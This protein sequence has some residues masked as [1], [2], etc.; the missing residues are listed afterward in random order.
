[1]PPFRRLTLED[2][3]LF[4][5]HLGNYPYGTYEYSFT[6]LYLWRGFCHV[7]HAIIDDALVVK[8]TE[9]KPGAFFMPP[10]G[11]TPQNLP[12]I[13]D[14]IRKMRKEIGEMPYLF[15]DAEEPFVADMKALYGDRL[16]CVEDVDNFDYIYESKDLIELSGKRYHAKKNHVNQ[17]TKS[18][19][20]LLKDIGE[21]GVVQ[22]CLEFA[23][24]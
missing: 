21:Q 7:Q 5:K 24:E 20:Y 16:I 23:R 19:S 12:R 10:I 3:D 2:R 8:K 11:Y 1:M 13:I 15:R 18:Y 22:D 6:T 9:C 17:F 4:L 14:E